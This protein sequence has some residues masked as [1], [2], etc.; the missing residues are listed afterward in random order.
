MSALELIDGTLHDLC[1]ELS[2]WRAWAARRV[3]DC[4]ALTLCR[5]DV[6]LSEVER[7]RVDCRYVSVALDMR[8]E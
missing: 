5:S 6:E 4:E 1:S 8:G 2:C 7:H 3:C